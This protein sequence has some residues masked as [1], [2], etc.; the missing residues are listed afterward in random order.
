MKQWEEDG[1]CGGDN[2]KRK[3]NT[4]EASTECKEWSRRSRWI[5][6]GEDEAG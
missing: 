2:A 1:E 3:E 5:G 6:M 4:G